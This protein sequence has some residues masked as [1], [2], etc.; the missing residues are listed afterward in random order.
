MQTKR[1][2][3]LF[4]ASS[5][6]GY[7]ATKDENLDWLFDVDGD[8]DNGYGDFYKT[9][10]TVLMGRTTYDWIMEHTPGGYPYKEKISY[11]FS[12]GD[13]ENTED[14]TFIKDNIPAFIESLKTNA[15]GK[16]WIVGG[17][18]LVTYFLKENLID[19]LFIT[20]APRIIGT[21]RS[22]FNPADYKL[23]L[24]LQGTKTFN[25]FVELHYT[26]DK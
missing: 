6:D 15:G 21:G 22:L 16:I 5:L 19:E 14:V 26:V 24:T 17:G 8:G 25:Q 4:I 23:N 11:I 7:I 1:T 13:H 10:D 2:L 9:I 3:T 18:E 12:R 20:V